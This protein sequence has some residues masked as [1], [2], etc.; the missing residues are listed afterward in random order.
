MLNKPLNLLTKFFSSS[1]WIIISKTYCPKGPE[2]TSNTSSMS[3]RPSISS[4]KFLKSI[5]GSILYS[6]I[7]CIDSWTTVPIRTSL[8]FIFEF[9][10]EFT[11]MVGF[12]V[13]SFEFSL[14]DL[15]N[16][17]I[18]SLLLLSYCKSLVI[19]G[20]IFSNSKI[21]SASILFFVDFIIYNIIIK[22][23]TC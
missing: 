16:L 3:F 17:K 5:S 12:I 7:E 2:S 23:W 9:S 10:I 13:T 18:K 11:R 19:A 14:E 21:S 15:P 1:E 8:L 22:D 6:F 20:F 4:L